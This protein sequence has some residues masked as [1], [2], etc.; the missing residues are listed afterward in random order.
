MSLASQITALATRIGQEIKAVRAAMALDNAVVH[1]TGDET[2]NGVKTFGS[3]ARFPVGDREDNPVLRG[4]GRL[5]DARTPLA[6]QHDAGDVASGYL[7]SAR[8]PAVLSELRSGSASSSLAPNAARSQGGTISNIVVGGNITVAGPTNPSDG[9]VMKYRLRANG[10]DRTVTFAAAA[11]GAPKIVASTG[12]TLGPY[13]VPRGRVLIAALEYV[14]D[15]R[16]SADAADP[17]WVLT[18]ATISG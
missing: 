4:D 7:S 8:M 12:V 17:A 2:V 3:A 15:R 18:A 6:H 1:R 9:Q 11:S 16:T 14:A 5:V 13:T 10:A